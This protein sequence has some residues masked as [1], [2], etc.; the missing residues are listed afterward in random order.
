VRTRHL[1]L[2]SCAKIPIDLKAF[3]ICNRCIPCKRRDLSGDFYT[4]I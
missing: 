4:T 2:E 1:L 3:C